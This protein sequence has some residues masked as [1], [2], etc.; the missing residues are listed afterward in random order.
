MTPA[1][2][3]IQS[4][5]V[6]IWPPRKHPVEDMILEEFTPGVA[7]LAILSTMILA[8]MIEE[9]LFRG[10]VQRWL[11]RL[12]SDRQYPSGEP[13]RT[14]PRRRVRANGR[15]VGRRSAGRATQGDGVRTGRQPVGRSQDDRLL[16]TC[17]RY[18]IAL[19]RGHASSPSGQPR[20]ASSCSPWRWARS[21]RRQEA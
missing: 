6:R 18:D 11:T 5:A 4:L 3:A 10:I 12:F 13:V 16:D 15:M 14:G 1:V 20:S 19:V 7:V 8:P 9:L 21:T 2:L 17:H